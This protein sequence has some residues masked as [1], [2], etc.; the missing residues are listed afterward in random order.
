VAA[1]VNIAQEAGFRRFVLV[2]YAGADDG[3][4]SPLERA[5]IATRSGYGRRRCA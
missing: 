4:G 3:L 5:K 1:F 2:S